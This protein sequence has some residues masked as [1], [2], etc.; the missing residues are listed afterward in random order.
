M[1]AIILAAGMGKRLRELTYDTPKCMVKVNGIPLIERMLTQ[2]DKLRLERIVLVIGFKADKLCEYVSALPLQSPV[3]Y[4]ENDIYYKTNNI[5]S[6]YL[7]K[8]HLLSSDT[9]LLE[10]DLIFEDILLDKLIKNHY[11]S[12][13]LV[14]KYESW[15]DGSV[16]SLSDDN[17]IK[18]FLAK[19]DF[20]YEDIPQ[21]Y[22]T[23]NIYKFSKSFS[24]THYVPFLE[25]YIKALGEN[26][27]Y[28]QVLKVITLLDKKGIKALPVENV[29]WYEIDD[30]QDLNIAESIFANSESEKLLKIEK[31]YGGYWRYPHMLDFCYLVNPFYPP[32]R[33]K[34]E[35]KANFNSLLESYPS[36]LEVNCLLAAKYFGLKQE[37]VI[38]GNGASEIIKELLG[39]LTGKIGIVLPTFEEYPNRKPDLIPFSPSNNDFHYT[40]NDIT[41]FYDGKD[42][43][44][45]VLINPDNPS[46]N[47][48]A[49]SEVFNLLEWTK[50]RNIQLILDESFI[51]FAEENETMLEKELLISNPHLIVIK[52]ISK[53]F[54]VAGLRLGIAASSDLDL[55]RTLKKDMAIWNIN[56]FGEFYLQIFEK[57][58]DD[59]N[60]AIEK[61]KQCRQ[62]FILG[63]KGISPLRTIP[64][65]ANFVMCELDKN[66][67]ARG[68]TEILL[69]Q[70]NI[71]IKD[72]SAK[73]GITG[74]YIRIAIKSPPEN[75]CLIDA[76]K[77]ILKPKGRTLY[78]NS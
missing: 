50:A 14:A 69:S 49:K 46:G 36:G 65:Q 63:L 32:A 4:I 21:Y 45:F 57:Y 74:E 75:D 34:N 19:K 67:S 16:V 52:S 23:I 44:S 71:L 60:L 73:A 29:N 61:F 10:S 39:N 3:E 9:L 27:Y 43:A 66:F 40:V 18:S 54:G 56:S 24:N 62:E 5:Y 55:I 70:H 68:L 37:Q 78:G 15:M 6:L 2:L 59:F 72:L 1:Q 33:L 26:E 64:T 51:D 47:Y 31:R 20:V 42:I 25:A 12:L 13:A 48:I 30:V 76:L 35:I 17:A 11:P 58:I 28:E 77:T 7:A 8:N 38:V 22:K 41:A 53:S